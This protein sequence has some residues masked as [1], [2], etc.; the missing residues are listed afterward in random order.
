[1]A[2][3]N[4]VPRANGEG[5]IGTAAK[6]WGS[7]WM[8]ETNTDAVMPIGNNNNIG[9]SNKKWKEG[10]FEKLVADNTTRVVNTVADMKI[11]N[12]LEAG[13]T[14]QTL[15]YYAVDDGCGETYSIT[16]EGI[17][18]GDK[19]IQLNNGLYAKRITQS[20]LPDI[21]LGGFFTSDSDTQA[22]LYVSDNGINFNKLTALNIYSRDVSIRYYNQCFY[23]VKSEGG[24]ATFTLYKSKDLKT[25]ESED[26][27]VINRGGNAVWA[28][29]LFIDDDG[30]AYVYFAYQWGTERVGESTQDYTA[31]DMYVSRCSNIENAEFETA[32]S[33]NLPTF[34]DDVT[35]VRGNNID[36]YVFKNEGVYYC[37]VKCDHQLSL[38]NDGGYLGLNLHLL[39]SANAMTDWTEVTTFPLKWIKGV[40]GASVVVKN[41]MV[42]IYADAY[43]RLSVPSVNFN[44]YGGTWCWKARLADLESGIYNLEPIATN[45]NNRHG[46][47][48]DINSN[49]A[50]RIIETFNPTF[51]KT[52]IRDTY[53]ELNLVASNN[54]KSKYIT[55]F[56]PIQRLIYTVGAGV[57]TVN[58]IKNVNQATDF[59][60]RMETGN[61]ARI[62]I[63]NDTGDNRD[64]WIG[65]GRNINGQILH[66]HLKGNEIM[67][68]GNVATLCQ[69]MCYGEVGPAALLCNF[70]VSSYR[71]ILLKVNVCSSSN[72]SNL[73]YYVNEFLISVSNSSWGGIVAKIKRLSGQSSID[74][75]LI[76]TG[77]G[78]YQLWG[79]SST[80]CLGLSIEEIMTGDLQANPFNVISFPYVTANDFP[81]GTEVPI[82]S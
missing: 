57:Y 47:V 15:G 17:V 65:N 77:T 16:T 7:G 62:H 43:G 8:D 49:Y 68:V 35:V 40:E 53:T 80:E 19:I 78:I 46:C 79:K 6:H 37:I 21:F 81:A 30:S 71:T 18:D 22:Q 36:G 69:S 54:G 75:K 26:F 23:L 48:I 64:L 31:L 45:Q 11:A 51:I 20:D 73:A 60:I 25:W 34:N 72:P 13:M 70:D 4:I 56:T 12:D 76:N 32:V 29:D 39:K 55:K 3:R 33:M 63:K 28:P 66:F 52:G 14:V 10:H 42:Y 24:T 61:Y 44:A 38:Q 59:Y 5:S 74:V 50:K 82:E 1:M 9:T 27:T 41:D 2:T 58:G 67:Y